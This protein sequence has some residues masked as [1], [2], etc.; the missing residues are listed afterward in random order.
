[1]SGRP[2]THTDAYGRV[3]TKC[4]K[5]KIWD[6]FEVSALGINGKQSQCRVCNQERVN[7]N[8]RISQQRLKQAVVDAYGGACACCGEARL[9]FLTI[10]HIGE[11]G[12]EHRRLLGN[13]GGTKFYCWL[14]RNQYPSGFQAL[15]WNCNSA[16]HILGYCPHQEEL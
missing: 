13:K 10:D 4:R 15:C 14:R 9:V 16:K 5:Y 11:D 6:E 7:R 2:S 1:M 12:A 8:N 3:C